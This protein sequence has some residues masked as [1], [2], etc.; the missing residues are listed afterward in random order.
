M[1]IYFKKIIGQ[2]QIIDSIRAYL[3]GRNYKK[4]V[5]N[6]AFT[7]LFINLLNMH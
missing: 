1:S 6:C 7:R 5:C 4:T 2:K 3:Y